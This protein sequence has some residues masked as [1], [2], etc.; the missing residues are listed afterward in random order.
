MALMPIAEAL[1]LVLKDAH[2]LGTED[3]ALADAFDRV[4]ANDLPALRTQPPAN[5]SAMDG[6]ALRAADAATVPAT[7]K[8]IGEVA[9]GHPYA[10][11]VGP[12]ETVRIFT[13]G[14]IPDDCDAIVIQEDT[15]RDGD[16]VTIRE[17]ARPGRHVRRAGIDFKEGEVLLT[18]GRRLGDRDLMV[19][20]SMNY[21]RVPVHRRPSL[22]LFGTGD[23]LVPPGT[24]VRAG[25][26]VYSNGY[27][28]AALASRAGASVTHAGIVADRMDDIVAAIR[29]ARDGGA[30]ILVTTGGASVGDY[31]LVHKALAAEGMSLSFWKLALRPGKPM[32]HG[33]LGS[34][35]GDMHVLGLPGNPVSAY[36]CSYLFLVPLIRKLSGADPVEHVTEAAI[37]GRDLPANDERADYMRATVSRNSDGVAVATPLPV[38]DSSLMATLSR[39]DCL[40]IRPP[41]APVATAGSPCTIVRLGL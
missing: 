18:R 26:I 29:N 11:A 40:V 12:G 25:E 39:A 37:L 22:V 2:P 23:E 41:H 17:A 15:Q 24:P 33:R 9:A 32:L 31:D 30:N 3:A 7:L 20:A 35:F 16:T 38:Q 21:P 14:V 13:G 27:G 5:V 4:L 36:V 34:R 6:Y 19:A 10:G 28:I 8:V 1:A